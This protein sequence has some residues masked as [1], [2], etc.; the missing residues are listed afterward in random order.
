VGTYREQWGE[1]P[2][3]YLRLRA[4]EPTRVADALKK[5]GYEVLGVH[6]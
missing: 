6:Q 1:S 5:R 4:S 2:V 3:F